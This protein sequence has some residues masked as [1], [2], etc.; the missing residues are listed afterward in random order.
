M[1][2][3]L[4][5]VF[6]KDDIEIYNKYIELIKL[7]LYISNKYSSKHCAKTLNI[8]FYLTS[9]EKKL[10]NSNINILNEIHINTAFTTSCP[11]NS[12]IV[13]YRKEEWFKVFIHE[14][15]HNFGLD[16]STMNNNV[17]NN[18]ILN[19]FKVKSDVNLY[20]AYAEFWAEIINSLI[21]VFYEMKNKNDA[22]D[23]HSKFE[24]IINYERTYSLFQL[25][26]TLNFMDLTY[27]DLYSNSK[28]SVIFREKLYKEDT[29]VLSYYIIKCL[30][31]NNY[32]GFL[33]WCNNNNSSLLDFKKT[34]NNQLNLCKFIERNYKTH[35]MILGVYEAQTFLSKI[36]KKKENVN[37][38]LTTM[39]MSICELG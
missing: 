8:Y 33:S 20:E 3:V 4:E 31:I 34:L 13:V 2:F 27:K 24:T 22:D 28:K 9:L 37:H 10:P 5:K 1:Y 39:R 32:Q 7:W 25:V 15:F 30:L 16:F 14:T 23:F 38:I 18:C 26:K 12:E 21:C 35:S 11:I 6:V 17:V 36:K 19:I 29:N